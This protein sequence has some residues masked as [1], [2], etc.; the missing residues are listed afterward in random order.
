MI[1]LNELNPNVKVETRS[2]NFKR[3]ESKE[4]SELVAYNLEIVSWDYTVKISVINIRP[5]NPLT[6]KA[7][8]SK[9]I[10]GV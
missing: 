9:A 4:L 6:N 7:I 5:I 1:I 10:K 8:T 2:A 3:S